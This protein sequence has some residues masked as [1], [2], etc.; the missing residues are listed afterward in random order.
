MQA[1][2]DAN[3]Q[4]QMSSTQKVLCFFLLLGTVMSMVC[5]CWQPKAMVKMMTTSWLVINRME[6]ACPEKKDTMALNLSLDS[7]IPKI[8]W[9]NGINVCKWNSESDHPVWK[10]DDHERVGYTPVVLQIKW[11]IEQEEKITWPTSSVKTQFKWIPKQR[12]DG[13]LLSFRTSTCA[14][15]SS[16][17][18]QCATPSQRKIQCSF[19]TL[20]DRDFALPNSLSASPSTLLFC[21]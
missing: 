4:L 17:R 10:N 2:M 3:Q 14:F 7:S 9:T 19:P 8:K 15:V 21:S 13:I 20:W 6:I 16:L 11:D 5:I 18:E 1:T 12:I